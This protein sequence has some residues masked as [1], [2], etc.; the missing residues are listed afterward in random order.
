MLLQAGQA[1]DN[2]PARA[3]GLGDRVKDPLDGERLLDGHAERLIR[4]QVVDEVVETVEVRIGDFG[5]DIF[6]D[7]VLLLGGI[8]LEE[9]SRVGAGPAFRSEQCHPVAI[10]KLGMTGPSGIQAHSGAIAH[11][12]EGSGEIVHVEDNI[13]AVGFAPNCLRP[14]PCYRSGYMWCRR[15]T[16]GSKLSSRWEAEVEHVNADIVEDSPAPAN[17]LLPN[18]VPRRGMPSRRSQ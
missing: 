3:A 18:Q 14:F 13:G 10:T 4:E 11:T 12:D 2:F 1:K 9:P 5:I 16:Q 7:L 8:S 15:P 6:D 17:S